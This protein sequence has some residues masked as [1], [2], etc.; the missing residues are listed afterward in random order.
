MAWEPPLAWALCGRLWSH[1]LT[2]VETR[3]GLTAASQ[4]LSI[5][6]KG[7]QAL[8][9]SVGKGGAPSLGDVFPRQVPGQLP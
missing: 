5:P 6:G 1:G 8:V 4:G 3:H 2:V 7:E 9:S